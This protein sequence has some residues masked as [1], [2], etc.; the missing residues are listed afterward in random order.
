MDRGNKPAA[1]MPVARKTALKSFTHKNPWEAFASKEDDEPPQMVD[2]DSEEEG[3]KPVLRRKSI[4]GGGWTYPRVVGDEHFDAG[5][6]Q[7][8]HHGP[9]PRH[10][11]GHVEV[12]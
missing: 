3:V 8:L 2:S 12:L 11:P 7:L 4:W 5:G 6:V 9:H 1:K 10:A